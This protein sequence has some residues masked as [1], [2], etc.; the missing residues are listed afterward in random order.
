MLLLVGD[1]HL[2]GAR[3][4]ETEGVA[5]AELVGEGCVGPEA[6]HGDA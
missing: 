4:G 5:A 6:L 1:G 2:V 3:R